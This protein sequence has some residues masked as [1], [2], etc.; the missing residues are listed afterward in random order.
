MTYA[1]I[2][3][4]NKGIGKTTFAKGKW[5]SYIH[6]EYDNLAIKNTYSLLEQTLNITDTLLYD[7]YEKMLTGFIGVLSA[8]EGIILDNAEQVDD[9]SL[10]LLVNLAKQYKKDM[11]FIFDVTFQNL[12]SINSFSR[13]IDWDLINFDNTNHDFSPEEEELKAFIY[14]NY[15]NVCTSDYDRIL[16]VTNNNFNE[17]K[18]LMWIIKSKGKE[19]NP[20]TNE[21]INEYLK[22]RLEKELSSFSPQLFEVLKKSSIIG[23]IFEKKPLVDKNCFNILGIS[24]YLQDIEKLDVYIVKYIQK[25]DTFKFISNDIYSAINSSIPAY[26]KNLWHSTL[27]KYYI[28]SFKY[29][30]SIS[31][32]METLI[33]AK[34]S[35]EQINDCSTILNLN[36]V[37]LYKYLNF[38][39]YSKSIKV[40]D[41]I[42]NDKSIENKIS[43]LSYLLSI[44]MKL[45]IDMGEYR[46]ALKIVESFFNNNHYKGSLD[47]LRYYHIKCLYNVGDIDLAY[48]EIKELVKTLK[49][50]SKEGHAQKIFPLVY[51]MMSTIQN[52][53]DLDDGG[54]SYYRLALNYSYNLFEDKSLYYEILSKCDMFYSNELACQKLTE[55]AKY[56]KNIEKKLQASKVY[57]NLAT[58]MMFNGLGSPENMYEYFDYAKKAFIIPDDTLA[59]V[60]NNLAIYYILV[61]NDFSLAINELESALFVNLSDF[62]NM[63]LYLNLSMCYYKVYGKDN[64]K[65][66]RSYEKF[67]EYESVVEN[68]KNRTKYEEVYRIICYLIF[69]CPSENEVNSILDKY[70]DLPD[71]YSFFIPIFSDLKKTHVQNIEERKY[72]SDSFFYKGI[73]DKG[74]FLAELRFWE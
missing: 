51:S 60:K 53:L 74:I 11:V 9:N 73:R 56:F 62:T 39:D 52:H 5:P 54:L 71:S 6:I 15:S 55:C 27:E 29:A 40:I 37:L 7:S 3:C 2:L 46:E 64:C 34:R 24:N 68:R 49:G 17:I 48:N 23:E 69:E 22:N 18:K 30:N 50:A 8:S 4:G 61:K 47:Y 63:T 32:A 65:F 21:I 57:L 13:L 26:Y 12:S 42:L 44:K 14:D 36:Q 28:Q 67:K 31:D 1:T 72:K 33:N 58:E 59:Y 43:Y 41:D 35:A 38:N 16:K 45:L 20:L 66:I 70:I 25:K 10:K 19:N